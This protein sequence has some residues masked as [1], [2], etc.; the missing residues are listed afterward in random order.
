MYSVSV[1]VKKNVATVNF[2]KK[3]FGLKSFNNNFRGFLPN[4]MPTN[5]RK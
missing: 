2:N 5:K 4:I 3:K 1:S